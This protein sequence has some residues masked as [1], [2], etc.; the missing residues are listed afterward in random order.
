ML[1]LCR[2]FFLSSLIALV[3]G[4]YDEDPAKP[5]EDPDV[6]ISLHDQDKRVERDDEYSD[7]EDEGGAGR[8][9]RRSYKSTTSSLLCDL[10]SGSA[11]APAGTDKEKATT[12]GK[13]TGDSTDAMDLDK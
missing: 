6:R 4:G 2:P 1:A 3:R 12:N 7:S 13:T 11:A 8:R 10:A 9:D 5:E